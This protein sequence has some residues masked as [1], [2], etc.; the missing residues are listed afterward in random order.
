MVYN[1][2]SGMTRGDTE[3]RAVDEAVLAALPAK[4]RVYTDEELWSNMA[5]FLDR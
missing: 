3:S 5:Y 1:T 4:G 2:H